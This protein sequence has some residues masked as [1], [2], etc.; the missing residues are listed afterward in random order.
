MYVL[1][2]NAMALCYKMRVSFFWNRLTKG[3]F[4][5]VPSVAP[6]DPICCAIRSDEPCEPP[7]IDPELLLLAPAGPAW[8]LGASFR[9]LPLSRLFP[10]PTPKQRAM[11]AAE[12]GV[13]PPP[14]SRAP[15]L[16]IAPDDAHRL[17]DAMKRNARG[18]IPLPA[19]LAEIGGWGAQLR[20]FETGQ[21]CADGWVEL[22]QRQE[23]VDV[24]RPWQPPLGSGAL[25][26]VDNTKQWGDTW[27][28]LGAAEP[29]DALAFLGC[30]MRELCGKPLS[31]VSTMYL[32]PAKQWAEMVKREE[33]ARH[34]APCFN[35]NED[36]VNFSQ[37]EGEDQASRDGRWLLVF[38]WC[39]KVAAFTGGRMIQLKIPGFG[40]SPMQQAEEQIADECGLFVEKRV[41]DAATGAKLTRTVRANINPAG[42]D[43]AALP[44]W[45]EEQRAGKAKPPAD[46]PP[47]LLPADFDLAP[48]LR[49]GGRKDAQLKGLVAQLSGGDAE[50]A[51]QA[52]EA[53]AVL[54]VEAENKVATVRA[55]ALGPLVAL[56][57]EGSVGVREQAAWALANLAGN[58]ENKVATV[59]AGALGPL[60]AML[61]DEGSARAREQAAGALRTL[62][63]NNAENQVAIVRAGA[64]GPLVALLSDEVSAGAREEAAAA[65][66]N[67]A[68]NNVKNQVL[69]VRA[70]ALG[71]LVALLGEG[72]A[73]A[74]EQAAGALGNL[75][76]NDA[77]KQ[78][79]IVRAGALGPLVAL[80]SEGSVGARERAAWALM[81]LAADAENQVAIVRAGALGPMIALLSEGSAGAREAAAGALWNLSFNAE[82][83]VAIVRA[84]ALG[85]LIALLGE[86]S[87][88]AREAAAGALWNLSF[89]AENKVAIVRAGAL[90]PLIALLSEGT[91]GAREK[92]TWALWNLTFDAGNRAEAAKLGYVRPS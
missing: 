15:P 51:E 43:P 8:L 71:P 66:R 7:R 77:K 58:A 33:E 67:L 41:L 75:A 90:G 48:M 83:K 73:G 9:C 59:R 72:S 54:A 70:G 46:W 32:S 26:V 65:L 25:A 52:A 45:S 4:G 23:R 74:R 60:I 35:P 89:N 92:A 13:P 91:A 64:L 86:G 82:N 16:E 62:A 61:S 81:N 47:G 38:K 49:E 18:N 68:V 69:I 3:E 36:N 24:A 1:R 20:A 22:P 31:L 44:A 76:V 29:Q 28:R 63:A 34:G 79:A 27:Q 17:I 50:A 85:P 53:L 21:A 88:G 78:V 87:A 12:E 39:A 14:P 37:L 40:L 30:F 56:L 84:G 2:M 5:H 55:G 11:A 10:T 57:S 42:L 80:L 6:S 19:L